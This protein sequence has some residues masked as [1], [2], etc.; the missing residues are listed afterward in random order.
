MSDYPAN[1]EPNL[2]KLTVTLRLP[3]VSL[4]LRRWNGPSLQHGFGNKPLVELDATGMFAELAIQRMAEAAGWSA[5]W[6]CT[7]GSKAEGPRYLRSGSDARLDDQWSVPLDAE[8][9]VLLARIAKA[10]VGV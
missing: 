8:R 4:K 3:M 2:K 7:F 9:D 1:F 10:A 6:V 5:R